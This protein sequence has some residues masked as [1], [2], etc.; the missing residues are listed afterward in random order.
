MLPFPIPAPRLAG[1]VTATAVGRSLP[2]SLAESLS[3]LRARSRAASLVLLVPHGIGHAR[4][5][6]SALPHRSRARKAGA[7]VTTVGQSAGRST[8]CRDEPGFFRLPAGRMCCK[9]RH[10]I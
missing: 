4:N 2:G 8:A 9:N 10:K 3:A 1:A 7:G 5:L 6:A